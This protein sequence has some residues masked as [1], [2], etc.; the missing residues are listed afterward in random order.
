MS[1]GGSANSLNSGG[2]TVTPGYASA[3]SAMA[4]LASYTL[5]GLDDVPA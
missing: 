5:G 3:F 4:Q 2:G 1:D